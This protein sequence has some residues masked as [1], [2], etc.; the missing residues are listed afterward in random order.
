MNIVGESERSDPQFATLNFF[1][2]RPPHARSCHLVIIAI[3][4]FSD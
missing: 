2:K 3:G 1:L 4:Q